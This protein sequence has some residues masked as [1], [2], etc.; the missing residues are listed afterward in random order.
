[1]DKE[2]SEFLLDVHDASMRLS[3]EAFQKST[4]SKLREYIDFDFAIWGGGDGLERNLHTATVLDQT[5][6][7]FETWEPVKS[8][9]KFADLVISNTGRTWSLSQV[10]EVQK[11]RA[12]N[13]HWSLYRAQQMISTMQTDPDTG[14]YVFVT[15]ARDQARSPFT[16]DEMRFKNLI[17]Q[18]LFLAARHNDQHY[19]SGFGAPVALV[20]RRGLLHG[21]VA[22]FRALVAAEWGRSGHSQLPLAATRALWQ[23]GAYQGRT[24]QLEARAAGQRLVV[25]AQPRILT[26]LS[27]RELEVAWAYASGKNH[28]DVAKALDI[29]PATVRTHLGRI[30]QKLNVKDKG[31]LALWLKDHG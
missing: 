24:I 22:D 3:A 19:L 26:R 4:L 30:Y 9:D 18:H 11:T 7:L 15:L 31:A 27:E 12:F 6:T 14:L 10:P 29:S 2:L 8:E 28:K 13:E 1:M 25:S 20:D 17:T 5:D 16:P 21:A 23:F